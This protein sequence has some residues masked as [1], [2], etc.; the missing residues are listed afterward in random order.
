MVKYTEEE[1]QEIKDKINSI[2]NNIPSGLTNWIWNTYKDI[3]GS[4]EPQPCSCGSAGRLWLKAAE[5]IRTYVKEN[6]R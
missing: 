6:D 4:N 5:T 2:T 1:F 3:S